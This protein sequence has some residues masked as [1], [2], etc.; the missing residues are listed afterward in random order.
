[1]LRGAAH[2]Y[3][4]GL[5]AIRAELADPRPDREHVLALVERALNQRLDMDLEFTNTD[6]SARICGWMVRECF[7][8][9]TRI[10]DAAVNG[11]DVLAQARTLVATNPALR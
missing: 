3:R 5:E 2:T 10:V 4:A 7:V 11:E 8:D 9:L 1:L 6:I